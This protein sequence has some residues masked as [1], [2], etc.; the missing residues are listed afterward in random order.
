M[1]RDFLVLDRIR[2]GYREREILKDI[3]LR[4]ERGKVV[5]LIGGSGCGKTTILRLI[6]GQLRPQ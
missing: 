5:A 4:F 3:S 2:F 1:S 6:G